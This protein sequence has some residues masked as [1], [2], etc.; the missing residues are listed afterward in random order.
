MCKITGRRRHSKD[1]AQGGLEMPCTLTFEGCSKDITK[2][3][4]IDQEIAGHSLTARRN[5]C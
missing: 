5:S 1:L 2:V 3:E 4:K